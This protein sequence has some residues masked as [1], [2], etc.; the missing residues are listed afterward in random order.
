MKDKTKTEYI[1][2]AAN[3]IKT[4]FDKDE[5]ITP[6]A[7][8]DKLKACA[9]EYRPD[10]WRRLRRGLELSQ[11][12][13]GYNKAAIR[14]AE[15]NNPLTKDKI[16]FNKNKSLIKKKQ[17]RAKRIT[18]KDEKIL[19]N[20]IHDNKEKYLYHYLNIIKITGCR[21]AEVPN[22]KFLNDKEFYI[23]G[24]KANDKGD[25]GLDRIISVEKSWA[26]RLSIQEVGKW[27][28]SIEQKGL[29]STPQALIKGELERVT[30]AIWPRGK[31]RPTMYTFRH[32][33]GSDLKASGMSRQAMAYVMGHQATDS[34]DRY[35][36]SRTARSGR[37]IAPS[38]DADLSVI[39]ETHRDMSPVKAVQKVSYEYDSDL[40]L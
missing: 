36:N 16:T 34:I 5:A 19:F 3:F 28:Y 38:A 25:R 2:I 8:T 24:A 27:L 39:R 23:K 7:I 35:G 33:L 15:T 13:L 37:E 10:Y 32:Q 20:Y 6:R 1:S 17:S 29:K 30:K 22:I 9:V 12:E 31:L 21:P 11:L 40:G 26:L 4:R 18:E 14:I